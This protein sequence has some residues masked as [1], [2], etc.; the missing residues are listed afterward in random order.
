MLE[1]E[2]TNL[3]VPAPF[4]NTSFKIVWGPGWK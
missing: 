4:L 1:L 2:L 3:P